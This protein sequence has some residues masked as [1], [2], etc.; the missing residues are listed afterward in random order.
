MSY[1]RIDSDDIVNTVFKYAIILS[2]AII[3]FSFVEF[4]GINLPRTDD[5]YA[6]LDFLNNFKKA[7]VTEKLSLLFS[8]HNEHRIFS[9]RIVYVAYYF[10]FDSINFK[11]IMYI[12][13]ALLLGIFYVFINFSKKIL[14][15]IFPVI[16][17]LFGLCL[18]DLTNFEN[19]IFSMA[20]MTNYGIILLFIASLYFY[21]SH[22]EKMIPLAALLQTVCVFSSGN[23]NIA[24]LFILIFTILN[25]DRIK[26]IVAAIIFIVCGI[27][28]YY[29]Y[30]HLE[31]LSGSSFTTMPSKFIPY[32]LHAI[33]SHFSYEFGVVSGVILL[34]LVALLFP[35]Q[36]SLV[37]KK[38]ALPFI[39]I[40]GF[41]IASMAVMAIYRGN[42]PVS[43]S[44][45][46]RYQIYSHM[47]VPIIVI[48]ALLKF[49]DKVRIICVGS[50]ILL[51][52]MYTINYSEGKICFE[53]FT[54]GLKFTDYGY[55]DKAA[56]KKIAD[57]SCRLGIY[58]I[59][60]ARKKL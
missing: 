47:L 50:T 48:F 59:D 9:A 46:S 31:T 57:E 53:G 51:I 32:F 25:K 54:N 7:G 49:P 12:D 58:C 13:A 17:F 33:G 21:S 35:V 6:I 16:S 52:Y 37:I 30:V 4:Y 24:S 42:L 1:N 8:Q 38:E 22:N 28:Y 34:L 10:I 41:I 15:E 2:P 29:H 55:D 19:A 45:S 43:L 44:Y 40:V 26:I 5:F 14:P 20:G 3:Y 36:K 23:G 56:A 39:C 60:S 18:F 11:Y 27:L